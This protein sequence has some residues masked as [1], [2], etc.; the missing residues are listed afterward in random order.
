M[1]RGWEGGKRGGRHKRR[2]NL[3]EEQDRASV[4]SASTSRC[5]LLPVSAWTWL[6]SCQDVRQHFQ[7]ASGGSP[8]P[9]H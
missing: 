2:R 9:T 6:A 4:L 3:E 8:E 1:E 5:T 7:M